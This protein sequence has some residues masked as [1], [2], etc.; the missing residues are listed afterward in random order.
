[1]KTDTSLDAD[2]EQ[3]LDEMEVNPADARDARH[4]R[5]ISAAAQ[6]VVAAQTELR[7]AVEEARRAGDSWAMIGTALGVSRQAAFQRFGHTTAPN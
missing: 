1:M 6:S 3:W 5:K 2:V 4:M 7:T